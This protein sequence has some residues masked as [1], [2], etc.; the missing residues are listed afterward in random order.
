MQVWMHNN[1][2]VL[3]ELYWAFCET[4]KLAFGR[5]FFQ[6]GGF[7]NFAEFVYTNTLF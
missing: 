1:Y 3:R 2:E 7:H 4:G 5:T 6:L